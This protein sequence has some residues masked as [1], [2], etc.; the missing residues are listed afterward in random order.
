MEGYGRNAEFLIC[1]HV[2]ECA[3]CARIS[4]TVAY[5]YAVSG[6]SVYSFSWRS[7]SHTPASMI[8]RVYGVD[9]V[10]KS[11]PG[12]T[13]YRRPLDAQTAL[14]MERRSRPT[15]AAFPP[16]P[17]P[18]PAPAGGARCPQLRRLGARESTGTP[19]T[20]TSRRAL[21]LVRAEL[22]PTHAYSIMAVADFSCVVYGRPLA[23]GVCWGEGDTMHRP[24][25]ALFTRPV[26]R[27]S[28]RR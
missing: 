21:S 28:Q 9:S 13:A 22:L 27:Q 5:G 4:L 14:P 17:R 2:W 18:P 19:A 11:I 24:M 26:Y 23:G 1:V 20:A 6:F 8:R 7:S 12:Y 25:L 15:P 3:V 16:P 10:A